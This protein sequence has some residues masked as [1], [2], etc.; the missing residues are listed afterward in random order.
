[1]EKMIPQLFLIRQRRLITAWQATA[2]RAGAA[3]RLSLT[4]FLEYLVRGYAISA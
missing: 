3:T 4:F 2:A 1:M